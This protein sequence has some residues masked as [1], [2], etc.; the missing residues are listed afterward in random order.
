MEYKNKR[1]PKKVIVVNQKFLPELAY[2]CREGEVEYLVMDVDENGKLSFDDISTQI[3]RLK[4]GIKEE[5]EHIKDCK[6]FIKQE[7]EEIAHGIGYIEYA[8]K[9]LK[10]LLKKSRQ[11]KENGRN[12]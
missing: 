7:Q 12:M 8:R 6:K 10:E 2:R 11:K 9:E 5:K 4:D 1:M 3:S